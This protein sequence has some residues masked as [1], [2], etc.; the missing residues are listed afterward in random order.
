MA[1]TDAQKKYYARLKAEREAAGGFTQTFTYKGKT[2]TLPT[3]FPKK[4]IE[5]LK[6]FLKSLDEWRAGGSNLES[7]NKMPSRLKSMAAAKK[8]GKKTSAF[9]NRAGS[10]WRRLRD[11]AKGLPPTAGRSGT[12]QL[13]KDFFDHK[14]PIYYL[15]I[16]MISY[17]HHIKMAKA[18]Y[19][20]AN[21]SVRN[22]IEARSL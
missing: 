8:V 6:E 11:Y 16:N 18:K 4:Q 1:R 14:G 10:I 15:F 13:Y 21:R 17:V 22:E 20:C 2:Y 12:G 5:Q 19:M 9:D 7:Y 3:R